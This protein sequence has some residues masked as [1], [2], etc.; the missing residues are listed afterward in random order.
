MPM[1]DLKYARAKL[2][3]ATQILAVGPGRIHERLVEAVERGLIM[4]DE[5]AFEEPGLNRD[6]AHFWQKIQT[7]VTSAPRDEKLGVYRPS[8]ARLSGEEACQIAQFI[9]SLESMVEFH[10]ENQ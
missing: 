8:I 5:K 4:V 10:L 3:D 9:V 6:A 2:G 1:A 7:A